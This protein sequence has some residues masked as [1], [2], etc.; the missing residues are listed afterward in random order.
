MLV[1]APPGPH[2]HRPPQ[3]RPVKAEPPPAQPA[4]L[5]PSSRESGRARR[6]GWRRRKAHQ[7][8]GFRRIRRRPRL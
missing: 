4:R 1:P 7:W 5:R 2:A 8:P 3:C 6:D